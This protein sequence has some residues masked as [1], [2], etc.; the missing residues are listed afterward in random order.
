MQNAGLDLL[1]E[2]SSCPGPPGGEERVASIIRKHLK[3]F[4][5]IRNDGLGSLLAEKAGLQE[6]PRLM[7]CAHMDEIGFMVQSITDQGLLRLQPLGGWNTDTLAASRLVIH[8]A[9]GDLPAVVPAI[10]PHFKKASTEKEKAEDI[11]ADLGAFSRDEVFERG[12]M[13]GD[14]V[15]PAAH[16]ERFGD[17]LAANKAWDDRAG[18]AAMVLAMKHLRGVTHQATVIAAATVQ[19][20]MGARGATTAARVAAPDLAIVLE[21]APA[22]DLPGLAKDEPQGALG[23]GCQIRLFDPTTIVNRRFWQWAQ[24]LAAEHNVPHQLAV[25]QSGSTDARPIHL[26]GRGIPT[27]I[28]STPVRYIHSPTA[29]LHLADFAATVTLLKRIVET[30]DRPLFEHISSFDAETGGGG[31]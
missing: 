1:A 17:L 27:L 2:L 16:F 9:S 21:A 11:L 23:R 20:E 15:T 10:P 31:S 4:C 22:D 30:L 8:T 13:L 12:V 3:D 29:L 5:A 6:H 28:L 24:K 19:E 18:C 7:L 26:T 25:R 14:L